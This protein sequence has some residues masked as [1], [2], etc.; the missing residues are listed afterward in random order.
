MICSLQIIKVS[1][2]G[3]LY[4]AVLQRVSV[5]DVLQGPN[6]FRAPFLAGVSANCFSEVPFKAVLRK[7]KGKSQQ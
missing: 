2:L 5:F 6:R 3:M 4:I 1:R 7:Q